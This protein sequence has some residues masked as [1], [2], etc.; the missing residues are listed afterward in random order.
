[1]QEVQEEAGGT[2]VDPVGILHR[3]EQRAPSDHQSGEGFQE[4]HPLQGASD[5][6]VSR[7]DIGKY[8]AE[9]PGPLRR[10]RWDPEGGRRLPYRPYEGG[11]RDVRKLGPAVEPHPACGHPGPP[12]CLLHEGG[13]PDAG[14]P[15][16][17]HE[18]RGGAAFEDGQDPRGLQ[19]PVHE[20]VVDPS[21]LPGGGSRPAPAGAARV[22]GG[23]HRPVCHRQEFPFRGGLVREEDQPYAGSDPPVTP[24]GALRPC[25]QPGGESL[26][27]GVPVDARKDHELVP[28]PASDDVRVPH[29]RSQHRGELL[30]HPVT[31]EMTP[32]VVHGLEIVQIDEEEGEA[33]T[34]GDERIQLPVEE[35][36]VGQAGEMIL[37]LHA[38]LHCRPC[39]QATPSTTAIPPSEPSGF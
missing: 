21:D 15:F 5:R 36:P 10:H 24:E 16:D 8:G 20:G 27:V 28:A 7:E 1:M 35:P 4:R 29:G 26:G 14:F 6:L 37:E 38:R 34:P 33:R 19:G 22:L 32:G 11:E 12:D 30:E 23:V 2:R 25:R 9:Y 39:R 17:Y 13:L 3:H 31:A 18:A